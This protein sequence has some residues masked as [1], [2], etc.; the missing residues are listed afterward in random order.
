MRSS[1]GVHM[2]ECASSTS[3]HGKPDTNSLEEMSDNAHVPLSPPSHHPH[4]HHSHHDTLPT[5]DDRALNGSGRQSDDAAVHHLQ[6][7]GLLFVGRSLNFCRCFWCEIG[8]DY[9]VESTIANVCADV[10]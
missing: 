8:T 3:A 10:C 7:I 6:V 9:D 4:V 5:N 2:S 1:H